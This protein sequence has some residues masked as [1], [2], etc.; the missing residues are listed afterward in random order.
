MT[1][2]PTGTV[3]ECQDQRSQYKNKD[4]ALSILRARLYEQAIQEQAQ[5]VPASAG[6]GGVRHAE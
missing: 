6:P 2:L 1:H 3:V 4:R 5:A